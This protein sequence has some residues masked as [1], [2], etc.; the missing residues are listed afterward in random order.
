[1]KAKSVLIVEDEFITAMAVREIVEELG[2]HVCDVVFAGEAAV[3]QANVHVPDL[4]LMDIKLA[5][6]M[7]GS[8]AAIKIRESNEI[9]VVFIT[10]H[11]VKRASNS[12]STPTP[13]G[14]GYIVKPFTKE[15]LQA[16]IERV[17]A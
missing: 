10:A 1:M 6:N 13:E 11:G 15:E 12:G 3:Q 2:Y 14:Y 8:E 7:N 16:E 4:V 9:P 17:L 5:G